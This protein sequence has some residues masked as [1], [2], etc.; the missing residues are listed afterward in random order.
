[1]LSLSLEIK[2]SCELFKQMN[3]L[4][5][6]TSV[7]YF[8]GIDDKIDVQYNTELNP[9]SFTIEDWAKS[10]QTPDIDRSVLTLIPASYRWG[11]M[12]YRAPAFGKWKFWILARVGQYLKLRGEQVQLGVWT[13]LVGI[14]DAASRA[15]IN[16]R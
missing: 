6:Q 12:F 3:T 5:T 11:Y 8:N 13:H 9:Q 7:L 16:D 14:Y 10:E 1:M 4:N 15:G 2:S